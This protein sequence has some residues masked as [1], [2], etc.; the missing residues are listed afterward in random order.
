[1]FRSENTKPRDCPRA[2]R[3]SLFQ[4]MKPFVIDIET[5]GRAD[6]AS[7]LPEITAPANY[8]D[9]AKIEAY[10]AEKRATQLDSAALSA[11]TGRI[12]CVGILREG[13]EPQ[14][15]HHDDESQ[16]IR[17]IWNHLELRDGNEQ[18]VTFCGHRFDF[19]F[20]MRRSIALGV[21]VP[22]WFPR[23]GRFPRHAFCD[24]AELW[25]CGDRAESISLDRLSCLCGLPGKNGSG[26]DFARLWGTDRKAALGYLRRDLELTLAIWQRMAS[27]PVT[28]PD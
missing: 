2:R 9:A 10:I 25:Q 5:S 13:M 12:V 23:D 14:F 24:L 4:P 21:P 7:Y 26:A 8:K 17:D 11:E 1:M 20:I 15:L 6:A 18:F 19:P 16:L 3:Q 28:C 27:I 22:V